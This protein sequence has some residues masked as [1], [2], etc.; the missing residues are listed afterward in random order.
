MASAA[1]LQPPVK[2]SILWLIARG[3]F[4]VLVGLVVGSLGGLLIEAASHRYYRIDP[5][6]MKLPPAELAEFVRGLPFGALAAVVVAWVVGSFVAA[7]AAAWV[8]GRAP[9]VHAAI[10][11]ALLLAGMVFNLSMIPHPLWMSLTAPPA[12]ILAAWL[13]ARVGGPATPP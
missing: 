8:A 6:V 12:M 4:A 10:P 9:L 1:D 11:A 13:G 2:P 7:F 3:T 5:D